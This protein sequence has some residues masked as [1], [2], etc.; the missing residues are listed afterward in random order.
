MAGR[1]PQAIAITDAQ[2]TI[3]EQIVRRQTS[4]QHQVR[5]ARIVLLAAAGETNQRI[6]ARLEVHREMVS[7]WRGRWASAQARLTAAE[8]TGDDLAAIIADVLADAPRPGTPPTFSAEQVVQIVALACTDPAASG[9]PIT[10][11]TPRELADE[12]IGR[13]IVS[14]ISPQ[15]VERFLKSGRSQTPPEP[16][17]AEHEG[18]GSGGVRGAGG[19]DL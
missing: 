1:H 12:A 17:L 2:R 4:P 6:A 11:W 3:L 5:R 18:D 14:T 9:R 15:S 8:Q 10:Q 13:G 19:N 7:V 16:L